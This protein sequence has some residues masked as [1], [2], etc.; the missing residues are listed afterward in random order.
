MSCPILVSFEKEEIGIGLNDAKKLWAMLSQVLAEI[1]K[2]ERMDTQE[3]N[4]SIGVDTL[5][6]IAEPPHRR[7]FVENM[8]KMR[9]D[10]IRELSEVEECLRLAKEHPEFERFIDIALRK[11]AW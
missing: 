11:R 7:T 4:P 10:L 1:N 6:R 8:E 5:K 3:R 9:S 2:E